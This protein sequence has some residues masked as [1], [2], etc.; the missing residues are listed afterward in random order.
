MDGGLIKSSEIRKCDF[1]LILENNLCYLI[2]L[3]GVNL[4][5]ACEQ[6]SKTMEYFIDK[7]SMKNFLGR[8]VI[9][10]YNTH[11][12]RNEKYIA[13]NKKLRQLQ[14]SNM[15]TSEL[16]IIKEKKLSEYIY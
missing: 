14:K 4:D 8:I 11:K 9:S 15:I 6:I 13:L 2:E 5:E 3:K 10:R 7:Y 16:L 1:V 12:L